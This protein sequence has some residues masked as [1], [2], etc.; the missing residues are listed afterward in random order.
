MVLDLLKEHEYV[1]FLRGETE[2][3]GQVSLTPEES[4]L[5]AQYVKIRDQ[6]V[7]SRGPQRRTRLANS[8]KGVREKTID[9]TVIDFTGSPRP[10][11]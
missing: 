9:R 1:E 10:H 4:A 5:E 3:T 2:N 11:W 8:L 7:A 6:L